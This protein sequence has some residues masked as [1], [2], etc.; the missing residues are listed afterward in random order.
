MDLKGLLAKLKRIWDPRTSL[1]KEWLNCAN[2]YEESLRANKLVNP[3]IVDSILQERSRIQALFQKLLPEFKEQISVVVTNDTRV[4]HCAIFSW[5]KH[6][7]VLVSA[8]LIGRPIDHPE[9]AGEKAWDWLAQ[10]EIS[11]LKSGHLP[12][13]F[14][15]RRVFRLTFIFL[16]ITRIFS[17]ALPSNHLVDSWLNTSLWIFCAGWS[18]QMIVSLVIEYKADFQ[19]T[20]SIKDPLVLEDAE[21]FLSRMGSQ[22]IKRFPQPLGWLNYVLHLLFSDPHPPFVLRQWLLRKYARKLRNALTKPATTTNTN[23][24]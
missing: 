8:A 21:Q 22:A 2:K 9:S 11:H 14:H 1:A 19:A 5:N 16:C 13:L 7:Y 23:K 6:I 20:H 3:Q 4:E 12:W 18:I 17:Y 24:H 15:V 10:H